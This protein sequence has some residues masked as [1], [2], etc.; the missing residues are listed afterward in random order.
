MAIRRALLPA[1]AGG[2]RTLVSEFLYPARGIGS[3]ADGLRAEIERRGEV[4]T[5]SLVTRLV[6]RAG[7]IEQV[8]VRHAG[9][10][11]SCRA[12]EVISSLPLPVLVRSLWPAA[13]PLVLEA[14]ARL[15]YRDLLLVAVRIARERVTDQTWIYIP[16]IEHAF[17]RVHE[18]KNWSREMGT[19]GETLL[20]TE[21]FCCRTDSAWQAAD[22]ALIERAIG[23][24]AALGLIRRS[25]VLDGLVVRVPCAYPLLEVGYAESC[26]VIADY[27]AG[28]ANLH[29]VGRTGAFRYFNMD[30]AIESGLDAADAVLARSTAPCAALLRTG[31]HA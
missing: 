22:D 28:F 7:R 14:A 26:R 6:H 11:A 4:R 31:T 9:A 17:G 5:D 24:L 19:A 27:L 25:D 8:T 1:A 18:P 29:A 15:R 3:I 13:P 23:G 2:P 21:H 30:H 10:S 20:V 12:R 16:G